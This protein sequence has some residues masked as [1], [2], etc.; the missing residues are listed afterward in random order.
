M[1]FPSR[2]TGSTIRAGERGQAVILVLVALSLVLIAAL[3]LA[4]DGSQLYS[5]RHMLQAAADSAAQAG[6]MSAFNK[7]NTGANAYGDASFTCTAT[8]ERTPC[9]YARSNGVAAPDSIQVE[10]PTTAPGVALST[11][12][13]PNLIRVTVTRTVSTSLIRMVSAP[14]AIVRASATAAIVDVVSPIPILVLHPTMSGAFHK[15]GSNVVK[16]CGGPQRSLQVN[17]SSTASVTISGVSGT[18]DLSNAGPLATPGGCDGTGGDMGDFGGPATFPGTILLGSA[19]QYIQPS[20]PIRDPL[21]DINPPSIPG[22]P[23]SIVDVAQGNNGCPAALGKKCKLYSPGLFAAGITV[24]NDFA[25]FKPG[26]YYISSGGF[27]VQA[28]G[29]VQMATGFGADATTGAGLLIYNTGNDANSIFEI[30]S[31]AGQISGVQY[32]NSLTGTPDASIYKGILFFQ[33]RS[34]AAHAHS[35][36]GGGGLT[37]R[38]TLYITNTEAIMTAAPAQYQSL[39]LQGNAGSTTQIIGEIIV[40]ALSLGGTSDIMMTLNSNY[41]LHIRQVALVL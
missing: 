22:T 3:G 20:S 18:V 29:V 33:D 7:T 40:G 26:I 39:N 30:T 35:L 27:H 38:G 32:G 21:I 6:I 16:I 10:F 2:Q 23:G 34:S 14:T 36:Q 11:F 12:D 28:N 31:N 19:G 24:K 41:T 9:V 25:L 37:L 4:I 8:D 1:K 13:T 15:N 17:S 5:H